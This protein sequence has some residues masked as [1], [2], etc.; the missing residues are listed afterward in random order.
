MVIITLVLAGSPIY[1]LYSTTVELGVNPMNDP[2]IKRFESCY[3]IF[4][5]TSD[6]PSEK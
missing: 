2:N 1:L 6:R 4:S 3:K 5:S